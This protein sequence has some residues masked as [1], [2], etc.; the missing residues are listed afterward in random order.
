MISKHTLFTLRYITLFKKSRTADMGRKGDRGV[1]MRLGVGARG[2]GGFLEG[3]QYQ[4][5]HVDIYNHD[6][7]YPQAQ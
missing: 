3:G 1:T 2:K 4:N 6:N 5:K 7:N